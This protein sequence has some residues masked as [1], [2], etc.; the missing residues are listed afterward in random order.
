[1]MELYISLGLV[2]VVLV[3]LYLYLKGQQGIAILKDEK[4]DLERE[5]AILKTKY[6]SELA[7]FSQKLEI[8]HNAKE[9]LSREFQNLSNKIFEQKS[10]EFGSLNQEQMKLLLEPFREQIRSFSKE[11]REQ[12][13]FELQERY[14]LK[15][16]LKNLQSMNEQLSK[17]A[18]NLTNALK[19]E[20]KTQ[21]NWG[22]MILEN[23]LESSGLRE[24][25]EYFLQKTLHSQEGE[26]YRP[27]VIIH[28]PQNRDI[29][30]DSKVSLR[31]YERYI[32]SESTEE[33]AEA[34][35]AHI[36][37]VSKHIKELSQKNYEKL[38]EIESLDFVLLF[39]PIE[40][41]FNLVLENDT[42]FFQNAYKKNILLVSPSTLIVTLRTIEHIWRTQKQEEYA[43][44]IVK[45]AE[46]MY[47]KLVLFVDE[48]QSIGASLQKAQN[49]YDTAMKR[50][51]LGNGN[52]IKRAQTIKS[53]GLQPKRE[54]SL[55]TTQRDPKKG[56]ICN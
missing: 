10:R 23:I 55:K 13:E 46:G 19:Y 48:M 7:A 12:F 51:S 43:K 27:D 49:S 28:L 4:K 6:E 17:E 33:K 39:M 41:A 16:E 32:N 20:S 9:E 42:G 30:V 1:M 37:S 18:K 45:E 38:E 35:K 44:K 3:L 50:L 31:A 36:A 15:N 25:E 56:E 5:Y 14:L 8:M 29:V 53:F 47:E 40:G 54:L 22:E 52:L 26:M 2:V 21:G 11:A 34:L 24:G